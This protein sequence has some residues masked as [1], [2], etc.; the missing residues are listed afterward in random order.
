MSELITMNGLAWAL[1][2]I[3]KMLV[4]ISLS[5][6]SDLKCFQAQKGRWN[7]PVTATFAEQM[8]KSSRPDKQM[9]KWTE[10]VC[11]VEPFPPQEKNE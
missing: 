11:L 5:R 7:S 4:K 6:V 10:A 3:Y 8:L 2:S 1:Q 9:V